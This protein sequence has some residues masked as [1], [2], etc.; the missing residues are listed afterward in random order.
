MGA[1]KQFN[2]TFT[3]GCLARGVVEHEGK[4][5]EAVSEG[6]GTICRG[7]YL[8]RFLFSLSPS[9]ERAENLLLPQAAGKGEG[10]GKDRCAVLVPS[11]M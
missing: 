11:G 10:S 7:C 4:L 1:H 5:H 9:S 3:D 6:T 2:E 8:E